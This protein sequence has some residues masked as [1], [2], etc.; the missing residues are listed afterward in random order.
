MGMTDQQKPTPP[1]EPTE[2]PKK[3][4]SPPAEAPVAG[5]LVE[6]PTIGNG[7]EGITT[8]EPVLPVSQPSS[9]GTE[10]GKP[11]VAETKSETPA[12]T[13]A[14]AEPVPANPSDQ[15]AAAEKKP[16]E[17]AEPVKETVV[18]DQ[19]LEVASQPEPIP[20][21]ERQT[22]K[23]TRPAELIKPWSPQTQDDPTVPGR[24][25]G[26]PQTAQLNPDLVDTLKE[27][28]DEP[29]PVAPPPPEPAVLS[30]VAAA[31]TAAA[32]VAGVDLTQGSTDDTVRPAPKV[33]NSTD[34]LP[35]LE[36]IVPGVSS[37][38]ICP[39]CAHQNRP[40]ELIC[41]NCGTSLI[42]GGK[43]ALGTRD[44]VREQEARPGEKLLD[45]GTQKAL[46]TAGGAVFTENMVL[47]LEIESGSNPMLIYPKAE[48]VLG[49][50]DPNTGAI[51]DVDLTAYAG[52]RL[53]VSRRHSIIRMQ[54][55]N[56][57]ITDLG[58]SNGT[59]LNGTRLP[60]HR[61]HQLRDGDEVR[62]GQMALRLYFQSGRR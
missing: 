13:G 33:G 53:G 43:A 59:Y 20:P 45:T 8:P 18:D 44:L 19:K 27:N 26:L 4:S 47:R 5:Q 37:G 21:S 54:D 50:R 14:K 61:P 36:K 32:K 60:P 10:S 58:S 7:S 6:K 3:N 29:R 39:N 55:K 31:V 9:A 52:Y 57:F 38:I 11:T 24:G 40:G 22:E 16:V 1:P 12:T 48:I 17:S 25:S 30:T 15:S 23:L 28:P 34:R 2:A 62:L 51:P 56:L 35:D 49:R 41:D 46:A 42:T